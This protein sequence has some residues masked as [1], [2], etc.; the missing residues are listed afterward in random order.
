[1]TASLLRCTLS[2][3][4][5]CSTGSGI[6]LFHEA[7][8]WV[9]GETGHGDVYIT[10]NMLDEDDSLHIKICRLRLG[11]DFDA[12]AEANLRPSVSVESGPM[13]PSHFA[14]SLHLH[15]QTIPV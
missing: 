6:S 15:R 4:R 9:G 11:D 1:M 14:D 7:G 5:R 13:K 3:S 2:S 12:G 8:V 10:S